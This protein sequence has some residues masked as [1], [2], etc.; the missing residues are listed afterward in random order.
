MVKFKINGD[1]RKGAEY[2]SRAREFELSDSGTEVNA[3]KGD[4]L[5]VIGADGKYTVGYEKK[6]DFFRGIGLL[7]GLLEKG[8][9][10]INISE[11]SRFDMCGIMIDCSRNA[12]LRVEKVI[13]IMSRAALM[14]L[15]TVMLYTEDTYEVEGY[16]YF[17][18]LRG[19]Y[20]IEEIK[21]MDS[22]AKELGIELIPCIQTL[23]HL[24]TALRW[25]FANDFR[26][27]DEALMADEEKTYEFI[28]AMFKSLRK[29]FSSK[30]IHIGMDEA[31][32]LGLGN[33]LKKHGYVNRFE[34]LSRHLS[35]VCEI[36]QRYDFKPMMWSDMF[37]R[38]GSKTGDYYDF[39][40]HMP[41][42]LSDMMPENISMVY[43]DYYNEDKEK[44]VGMINGHEQ[45]NRE[46]I[47][48]GGLWGWTGMGPD[49]RKTFATTVPALAACREKGVK[50]VFATIWGD[51]G[52]EV[53]V[54]TNLLGMQLYGEYN[55][56]EYVSM[57]KL[58]ENFALC[59]GMNADD[60][61]ALAV[62]NQSENLNQKQNTISRPIVYQDILC[63]LFDKNLACFDLESEYSKMLEKVKQIPKTGI[64]KKIFEYYEA[65]LVM[66]KRKC[67]IGID[68]R[69]AYKARDKKALAGIIGQMELLKGEYR[70]FHDKAY[71]WWH[72]F[73]K[74]F[75]FDLFDTRMGGTLMRIETAERRIGE[76]LDGTTDKIDELEEEILWYNGES[77]ANKLVYEQIY[78]QISSVANY[79]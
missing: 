51:D 41:E 33:Y 36:A 57:D 22:A 29:G 48:A 74:P 16:E 64:M 27:Y 65:L 79:F 40:A 5:C 43:W 76:Y 21:T 25:E 23:A 60:F 42:N 69:K 39:D 12:V 3:V 71:A 45:M 7:T 73:N 75:G 31:W 47:F 50:N 26:D 13:D 66:M 49:Y 58:K 34:M 15:N 14:G 10:N 46:I 78:R 67:H 32:M 54:Y 70:E 20:S 6:S 8:E 4:K 30:R 1:F 72:E 62:D 68:I 77:N 24:K 11:K 18:Y 35:R 55:Y 61:L 38:L 17:G 44:Y 56:S 53:S 9:N 2:A 37:F 63:G 59:T 52:G 28:E 19:K